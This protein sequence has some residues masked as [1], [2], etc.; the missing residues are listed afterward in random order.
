MK[1]NREKYRQLQKDLIRRGAA[2]GG[3]TN[4]GSHLQ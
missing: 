4:Q 1:E 2:A 3:D